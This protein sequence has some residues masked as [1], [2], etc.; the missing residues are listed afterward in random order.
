VAG[1]SNRRARLAQ[2]GALLPALN[3]RHPARCDCDHCRGYEEGN[4]AARKH[5]SYSSAVRLSEDPRVAE[6]EEEI[7]AT[8]P[9][10]HAAD[11]GARWRLALVYRRIELSGSSKLSALP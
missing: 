7:A 9:I 6:I 1:R 2:P 3:T 11:G 5:G 10:S 4:E 8:Q